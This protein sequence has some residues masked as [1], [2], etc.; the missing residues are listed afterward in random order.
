MEC[1]MVVCLQIE[2]W[3]ACRGRDVPGRLAISLD[4]N[5]TTEVV[6]INIHG[7]T[8]FHALAET[9]QTEKTA[10]LHIFAQQQQQ[11]QER[12]AAQNGVGTFILCD[13]FKS[14]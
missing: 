13:H 6:L 8:E 1:R 7:L 11:H 9:G 14:K 5:L 12:R 4:S 2:L 10:V 3:H